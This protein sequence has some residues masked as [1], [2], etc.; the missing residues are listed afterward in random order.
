[1]L[2]FHGAAGVGKS[3]VGNIIVENVFQKGLDSKFYHIFHGVSDFPGKHNIDHHKEVL[4]QKII[5]A[6]KSCEYSIIIFDECDKVFPGVI[7][8]RKFLFP[9][10][11]SAYFISIFS[12]D[13]NVRSSFKSQRIEL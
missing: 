5:A 2:S 3:F 13:I 9:H 4:E 12:Y 7:D 8:G 1:M 10:D 6:I 11:T